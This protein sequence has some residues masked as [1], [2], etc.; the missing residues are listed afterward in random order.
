[1]PE[2][3]VKFGLVRRYLPAVLKENTNGWHIEY[4][5]M[6]EITRKLE[7]K[8][9]KLNRERKKSRTF[10]EFRSIVE[11]PEWTDPLRQNLIDPLK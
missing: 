8:R 2:V 6:N 3:Q 5:A 1:M 4:Y 10:M 11:N 7:R 9:V